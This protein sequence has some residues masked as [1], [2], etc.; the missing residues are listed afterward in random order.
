MRNFSLVLCMA[1]AGYGVVIACD[2]QHNG[3]TSTS[4]SGGSPTGATTTRYFCYM[5]SS[6]ICCQCTAQ[7]RKCTGS[8]TW[9]SDSMSEWDSSSGCGNFSPNTICLDALGSPVVSPGI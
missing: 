1:I 3:C 8:G 7:Y 9:A 5:Q 2:P 6:T 4:C